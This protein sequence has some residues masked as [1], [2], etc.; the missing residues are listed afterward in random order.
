MREGVK[1]IIFFSFLRLE[2]EER[3]KKHNHYHRLA[4]K[5]SQHKAA[6]GQENYHWP[7]Q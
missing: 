2:D 1:I 7:M 6:M 5:R 4:L 3:E